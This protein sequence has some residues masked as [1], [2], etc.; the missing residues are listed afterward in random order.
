MLHRDSTQWH[1]IK[2]PEKLSWVCV[3][4]PGFA[5][6]HPWWRE[7]ILWL[8]Q[9]FIQQWNSN[10]VCIIHS[11]VLRWKHVLVKAMDERK[12]FARL[13]WNTR[14]WFEGI[15][16]ATYKVGNIIFA[17]SLLHCLLDFEQCISTTLFMLV[18]F[19]FTPLV[20]Y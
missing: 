11:G 17:F 3:A 20:S 14:I 12:P 13:L 19:S 18:L 5:T 6:L 8:F 9:H 1:P 15:P 4:I 2:L 16:F 10:P 7:T